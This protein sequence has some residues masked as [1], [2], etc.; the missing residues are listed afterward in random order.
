MP[1][2]KAT[3]HAEQLAQIK[4]HIA[5]GCDTRRTSTQKKDLEQAM[6]SFGYKR[7]KAVDGRWMLT[8]TMNYQL[9]NYQ[10]TAASWMCKR[11]VCG[12]PSGGLIA[13][14]MGMGKTVVSLA[15]VSEHMAEKED[16]EDY[17]K[18]TLVV[19][20]SHEMALQ[21]QEEIHRH[22]TSRLSNGVV[23]YTKRSGAGTMP[24]DL[25]RRL[26]V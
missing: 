12:E 15:C 3:T 8:K 25:K 5:E 2:I 26:V 24:Q 10:L 16:M 19:V 20:P 4:A 14:E 11:E 21:W 18:T 13:D 9:F 1:D 17:S 23:V 6:K 7:V 22:C